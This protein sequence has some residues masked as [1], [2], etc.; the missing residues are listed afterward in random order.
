MKSM[1]CHNDWISALNNNELTAF[2]VIQLGK[3][4]GAKFIWHPL[5]FIFCKLSEEGER[6]IRLHI[7]PNH[8]DRMQKPTWLIHDHLFD[9]K[10]WVIAG[11]IENTEYSVTEGTPN[12]RVYNAI[13]EKDSSVLC[14]TDKQIFI[15]EHIKYQVSADEKYRVPSGVL[16]Q[17]VSVSETISVTV[18]ETIDQPNISPRIAGDI[19]GADKYSYIRAKVDEAD[20]QSITAKI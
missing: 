2:D 19:C 16:H 5:G 10:S 3:A 12:Y 11:K 14:R 17:S 9:L 13:Y 1:L 20:L 4:K 15:T 18:C 7:W 8:H 6:K